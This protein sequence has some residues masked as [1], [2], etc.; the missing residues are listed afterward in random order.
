MINDL[1]GTEETIEI[2]F[3]PSV[4]IYKTLYDK[5]YYN[6][7][8]SFV[9]TI[10]AFSGAHEVDMFNPFY[11]MKSGLNG[12]ILTIRIGSKTFEKDAFPIT[13]RSSTGKTIHLTNVQP[14]SKVM[15]IACAVQRVEGIPVDQQRLIYSGR[16]L[17]FSKEEE[18]FGI[19]KGSI[20]H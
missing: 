9:V 1:E 16:Q 8:P 10:K 3:A 12:A 7:N 4:P 14:H 2:Q 15:A 5:C 11:H 6:K 18:N 17:D 20:I 19:G 13:V